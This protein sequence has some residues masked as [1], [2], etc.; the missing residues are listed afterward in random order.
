MTQKKDNVKLATVNETKDVQQPINQVYM[1]VGRRKSSIAQIRLIPGSGVL[2][3]NNSSGETYMNQN[4]HLL[5]KINQPL[6]TAEKLFKFQRL[7]FDV[8]ICV[9]GGGIVGQSNAIHLGLSRVLTSY[10]SK[11]RTRFKA[12]GFLKRDARIKER[13]KYGLKKARKAPQYSKR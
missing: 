5:L 8:M 9:Q 2:T 3:I 13:K 7:K 11:Y 10:N 12:K 4:P 6:R 1:A